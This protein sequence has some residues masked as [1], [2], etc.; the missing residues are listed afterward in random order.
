MAVVCQNILSTVMPENDKL[1]NGNVRFQ[2]ATP[3][4]C[5]A[6]NLTSNLRIIRQ[7]KIELKPIFIIELC[8]RYG[9]KQFSR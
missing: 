6:R 2:L 3:E 5:Q 4:I 9:G 8:E 7:F 1:A